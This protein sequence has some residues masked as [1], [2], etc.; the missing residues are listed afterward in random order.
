M[1]EESRKANF[2]LELEV[3]YLR[4]SAEE[5]RINKE[6]VDPTT[7]RNNINL[8]DASSQVS[9]SWAT[10]EAA[11]VLPPSKSK[12]SKDT[13]STSN[14][15]RS[16]PKLAAEPSSPTLV[17]SAAW[18]EHIQKIELEL[19]ALKTTLEQQRPSLTTN[20]TPLKGK[21]EAKE[22]EAKLLLKVEDLED[23]L[24]DALL[25]NRRLQVKIKTLARELLC[26][27]IDLGK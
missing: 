16:S 2:E 1:L 4:Q 11:A 15:S 13:D 22:A 14:P 19:A 18:R 7:T 20:E 6:T 5:D 24:Y 12:P 17:S 25:E 9:G 23:Q 8:V 21:A 10:A 27:N 26:T 3:N